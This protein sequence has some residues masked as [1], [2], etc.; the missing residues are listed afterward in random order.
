MLKGYEYELG[1]AKTFMMIEPSHSDFDSIYSKLKSNEKHYKVYLKNEVPDYFHFSR[2]PFI[3][4]IV[5]V[6]EMG[7]SLVNDEWLEGLKRDYTK[8]NHGYDNNHTD[9]HGIFIAKGP[10]LKRI[11]KLALLWN[12]DINPLLCEIFNIQPR[13]NIDGK[14]ERIE[15]ILK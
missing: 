7:W 13:S 12:I 4:S 10:I 5:L 14:L 3:S 15:F 8:G 1:G 11:I 2:H 6:A 9:M